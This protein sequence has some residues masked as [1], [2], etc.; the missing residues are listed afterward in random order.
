MVES[1]LKIY[2]GSSLANLYAVGYLSSDIHKLIA[3]SEALAEEED[4]PNRSEVANW[5]NYTNRY[6][7]TLERHAQNSRI[8]RVRNGSIELLLGGMAVATSIIVP[9]AIARAQGKLQRE[10]L[11]VQFEVSPTDQ[12]LKRHIERYARGVYGAGADGLNNL[13]GTLSGLGYNVG[14]VSDNTYEISRAIDVCARRIVKTVR[15]VASS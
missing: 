10:G 3:L 9:I 13:F 14:A 1:Q 12:V 4:T 6:T 8:T 11:K 2:F 5:F 15:Y 7:R